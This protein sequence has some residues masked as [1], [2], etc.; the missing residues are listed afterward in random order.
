MSAETIFRA[1]AVA[2]VVL[3]GSGGCRRSAKKRCIS[4]LKGFEYL[5][6]LY[7]E[8]H[9]GAYPSH[10]GELIPRYLMARDAALFLCREGGH[11]VAFSP[12][13]LPPDAND[14]S[15][16][17]CPEHTDYCYV[18][19]L[20]ST[21]NGDWV[22]M[23]DRTSHTGGIRNVVHLGM[24]VTSMREGELARMLDRTL[25]EA[26]AAGLDPKVWGYD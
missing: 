8:D 18:S 4:Q 25:R 12:A 19:G 15:G 9:D 26:K 17:F 16:V 3:A 10:L 7:A 11:A 5:L 20:V 23:F 21:G 22:I 2:A 24:A 1:C 13:D 14:A 6:T